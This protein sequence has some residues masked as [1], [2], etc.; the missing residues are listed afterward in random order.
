MTIPFADVR[1]GVDIALLESYLAETTAD[2]VREA[3][4][5]WNADPT[6]MLSAADVARLG[7]HQEH[8]EILYAWALDRL[9][10]EPSAVAKDTNLA[11]GYYFH[12][13]MLLE[14][15]RPAEA[16]RPLTQCTDLSPG[17]ATGWRLLGAAN[18]LAGSLEAGMR[19]LNRVLRLEGVDQNQDAAFFQE[20]RDSVQVIR[21]E[22]LKRE[23]ATAPETFRQAFAFMGHDWS[24]AERTM[25]RVAGS[26][27]WQQAA[28][29]CRAY[30]LRQLERYADAL[31]L[32]GDV[33]PTTEL[34]LLWLWYRHHTIPHALNMVDDLPS[35][36][37]A[38]EQAIEYFRELGSKDDEASFL[39]E[40]ANVLKQ[41]AFPLST[42][43]S[44]FA[45][46]RPIIAAAV[47]SLARSIALLPPDGDEMKEELDGMARIAARVGIEETDLSL[48]QEPEPVRRLLEARFNDVALQRSRA[49]QCF[50][51]G[52][53]A[54]NQRKYEDAASLSA[55][56]FDAMPA[57]G[58]TD[59]A[60]RALIAYQRGLALLRAA[61][62]EKVPSKK[63]PTNK[64]PKAAE[65]RE[66]WKAA[67]AILTS[68]P[69]E[70]VKHF[71]E[72]LAPGA[73]SAMVNDPLMQGAIMHSRGID[74]ANEGKKAEASRCLREA[75]DLLDPRVP[76]HESLIAEAH[77]RSATLLSDLGDRLNA[78]DHARWV[79]EHHLPAK[80][81]TRETLAVIAGVR[82]GELHA[83]EPQRES[84]AN[85]PASVDA[86]D[87]LADAERQLR[88]DPFAAATGL[89]MPSESFA[90]LRSTQRSGEVLNLLLSALGIPSYSRK[91]AAFALGQL[92]DPQA[93]SALER[94][95]ASEP[96]R[97]DV[98]A[99][100]AALAVLR[101]MPANAG[102]TEADRRKAVENAYH[103]RALRSRAESPT[104]HLRER[105]SAQPNRQPDRATSAPIRPQG[106]LWRR[107]FGS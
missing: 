84:V 85:E 74:L 98:E 80:A 89:K 35:A 101:E 73:T 30:C 91:V 8:A 48:P 27:Y 106:G 94:H 6:D 57:S 46:A 95:R 58:P 18:V 1:G 64:L 4:P 34:S 88:E 43:P 86:P 68:L 5:G 3:L 47:N 28:L 96:S 51:R 26:P 11:G 71:N 19:C 79:L 12:G 70:V 54:F 97:G 56:A 24:G 16:V 82:P 2:Q 63:I 62:L 17:D 44:T 65:I 20:V 49:L 36:L 41:Q 104:R 52:A 72:D 90:T 76:E 39:S 77:L 13:K 100:T 78:A 60:F 42:D 61:G 9:E 37:G 40:K 67:L 93:I 55:Q 105:P 75:L 99:T 31:A 33:E 32:I 23:L 45:A 10:R 107:L 53:D 7:G 102:S 29:Y 21:K 15:T 66:V 87:Y 50:D 69:A 92:G 38:C 25:A 22:M 14:L 83:A 59:A 103:G 81:L